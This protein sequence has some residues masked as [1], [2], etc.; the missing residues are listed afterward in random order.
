MP[1]FSLCAV[2]IRSFT[3]GLKVQSSGKF[4]HSDNSR[5]YTFLSKLYLYCFLTLRQTIDNDEWLE[6]DN[7]LSSLALFPKDNSLSSLA[8]FPKDNSLSSLALSPKDN[9]LSSLALASSSLQCLGATHSRCSCCH[10]VQSHTLFLQ[11]SPL[12]HQKP[13][14]H[15]SCQFLAKS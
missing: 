5:R 3:A 12:L 8:L 9:S 2:H 4:R 1:S 10:C 7:S 11:A 13:E 14:T 6:G 15:K